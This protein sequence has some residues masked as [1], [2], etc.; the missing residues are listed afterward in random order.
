MYS[1]IQFLKNGLEQQSFVRHWMV[2]HAH[3]VEFA[4]A[5]ALSVVDM[6]VFHLMSNLGIE[7][8]ITDESE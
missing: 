4:L 2:K 3:V 5:I 8:Q 1:E 6:V 7:I